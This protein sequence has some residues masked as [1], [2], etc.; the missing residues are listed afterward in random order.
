MENKEIFSAESVGKGHPDKMCDQISDRILDEALSQDKNSHVACEVCAMNRLIV[1]GGE[2]RTN[3]T[4]NVQKCVWDV[5]K[6][7][8]Y[9][10]HFFTIISN[11]NQQSQEIA[12]KVDKANAED[13]GA[14]DQGI[15]TGYATNETNV[16]GVKGGN[17]LPLEAYLAK[18]LLEELEKRRVKPESGW[19]KHLLADMKSQVELFKDE[20]G[21]EI[22]K[23][24]LAIQH[25]PID[26]DLNA[27]KQEIAN[28]VLEKL[29]AIGVSVKDD[30]KISI[31]G[32]GEFTVGGPVG[33]SGLTGRKLVVDNY[34]PSIAIGG[35]AFSGKDPS[36]VDRSG[37][38]ICRWIAK[39]VVASKLADKCFVQ[40]DWEI[41][42][43]RPDNIYVNTY[44]TEK[45]D[46]AELLALIKAKF[47]D[48]K[49]GKL[50]HTLDLFRPIYSK[51][52]VYGHFKDN[53]MPWE[54]PIN[55]K[56]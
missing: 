52:A 50:V 18:Y 30:V 6:P 20:T 48:L 17:Y 22:K 45:L 44:G 47:F 54:K 53:K 2:I 12:D 41:G 7:L 34:G 32:Y 14:G 49:L 5:I 24:V 26:G 31:N 37:A 11:L 3:A 25:S 15:T 46:S 28:F 38:Y 29:S 1:V 35:G 56:K 21:Y 10:E 4:I 27:W 40:L 9:D 39:S 42:A 51:T 13:I 43:T 19:D 55:L 36:K 33:D 8:G 16:Y 23:I